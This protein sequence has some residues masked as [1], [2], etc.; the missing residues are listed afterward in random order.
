MLNL[1]DVWPLFGLR[2]RTPRLELTPVQDSDLPGL[3][4]AALAGIHD[5]TVM[6]FC[7]PWT[8]A[9]GDEFIR[10]TVKYQWS[11]RARVQPDNWT[12]N[13]A[14]VHDGRVLGVQDL[15][16][17]DFSVTKTVTTGSWLSSP[18]QGSGFGKEM[19]AAV[20]LLA[21]DHLGAE[22]AESDAA[23]WN[24]ASLGVSRALGY[25]DNG[26]TRSVARPG[27]L[28]EVQQ[29]RVTVGDFIRPDWDITVSG[30]EAAKRDLLI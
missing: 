7:V 24:Q 4:E 9:T 22:I 11:V 30:L 2:I 5:P 13:F 28:Q 1:V 10:E 19:R 6:P 17:K 26:V 15:G 8:D 3:I 20:L 23:V 27:E 12:V 25:R 21:F 14:V 16:T 18:S 29:L